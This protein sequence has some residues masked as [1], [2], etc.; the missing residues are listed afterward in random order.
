MPQ[1]GSM[2]LAATLS[3]ALRTLLADGEFISLLEN[4]GMNS[5][6]K[7]LAVRVKA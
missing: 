3:K 4:E 1:T 2:A 6:P 5:L 7:T